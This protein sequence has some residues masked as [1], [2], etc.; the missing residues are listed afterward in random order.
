MPLAVP[1]RINLRHAVPWTCR[2]NE[3]NTNM[4]QIDTVIVEKD[5]C[6]ARREPLHGRRSSLY[7]WLLPKCRLHSWLESIPLDDRLDDRQLQ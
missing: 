5:D 7:G 1:I 3:S 4:I 2:V 6:G